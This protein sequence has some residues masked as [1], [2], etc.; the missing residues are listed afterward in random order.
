MCTVEGS[1]GWLE[2]WVAAP[3]GAAW[4]EFGTSGFSLIHPWLLRAFMFVCVWL[5]WEE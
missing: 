2:S 5:G 4:I 3:T 1:R